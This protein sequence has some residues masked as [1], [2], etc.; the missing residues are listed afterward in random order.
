MSD[1][2]P[3]WADADPETW[4]RIHAFNKFRS[5][6]L[7]YF[8]G[9]NNDLTHV[10]SAL[11]T[12]EHSDDYEVCA[13]L[14]QAVLID[15]PG[16]AKQLYLDLPS[17]YPSQSAA[18]LQAAASSLRVPEILPVDLSA[19]V[20]TPPSDDALP[21]SK[22]AGSPSRIKAKSAY[23][24]AMTRIPDANAMTGRELFDAIKKDGEAAEMLPPTATS[25]IT[26]LNDCG[27]RLKK[28]GPKAAGG[29]VVRRCDL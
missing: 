8:K 28:C 22:R 20:A 7:A 21:K 26:Y 18:K 24:Y 25:F 13:K 15:A 19:E 1:W 29:S 6:V 14:Y 12:I 23:D 11:E 10:Q 4:K 27:I 3:E 17:H 9:I 2:R 16:D 5:A